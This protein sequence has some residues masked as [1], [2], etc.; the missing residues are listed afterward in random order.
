MSARSPVKKPSAAPRARKASPADTL[1]SVRPWH[2]FAAATLVTAVAGVVAIGGGPAVTAVFLTLAVCSAGAAG[3]GLY[4][5]VRPLVEPEPGQ[6]P[7]S[8]GRRRQASLEH[9]TAMALQAIKELEF[10]RAMGKV[11][12]SDYEELGERLR[13]RAARLAQQVGAGGVGY[14]D[15][16]ERD[17]ANRQRATEGSQAEAAAAPA[18]N[19]AV[20][21]APCACGR[22]GTLNDFDAQFCKQCGTKMLISPQP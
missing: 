3:F 13:A 17:V 10:D 14:R 2:L 5:T 22:C 4:R 7:E 11:P 9:E 16:I 6:I 20:P 1:G 19:V 18:S 15:L 21:G 8:L 12:E